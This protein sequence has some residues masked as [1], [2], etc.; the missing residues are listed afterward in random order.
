MYT[1]T[2]VKVLIT[3]QS[4]TIYWVNFIQG[5]VGSMEKLVIKV[6]MLIHGVYSL[7]YN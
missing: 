6:S 7:F 4:R 5:N 2:D 1:G 3:L